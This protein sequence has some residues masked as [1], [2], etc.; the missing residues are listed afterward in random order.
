MTTSPREHH[1]LE[2]FLPP[3]AEI[4]MLGSFPPDSKRWSMPFFYPNFQNDMWR[5]FGIIYFSDASHFIA[6][7]E[8]KFDMERIKSF[9]REKKIAIYDTAEV[10]ER[11]KGTASDKDLKVVKITNISALLQ[12]IP[13]CTTII[14]TGGKSA[15]I[16]AEQFSVGVPSV[17][18]F[19][20]F[21][22]GSRLVTLFR[23]PSSSRAYPM[24]MEE[25]ASIYR[26]ALHSQVNGTEV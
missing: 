24:K 14:S 6:E 22:Y 26:R 9:L 21:G 15:E 17:G 19:V 8:K 1:P 5:I 2:P 20:Q 3:E 12:K 7:G 23:A 11:M 10:V 18:D 4:L 25:K 13:S 16:C